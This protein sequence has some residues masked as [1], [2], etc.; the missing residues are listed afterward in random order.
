M[1][2]C[3]VER[4]ICFMMLDIKKQRLFSWEN[5]KGRKI[6]IGYACTLN[7]TFE[8][9]FATHFCADTVKILR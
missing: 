5:F 6:A 3:G 7:S 2:K 9:L 1:E 4:D 8:V